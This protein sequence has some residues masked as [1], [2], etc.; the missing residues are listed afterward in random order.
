MNINE[1]RDAI[2]EQWIMITKLGG[3]WNDGYLA[4]LKYAMSMIDDNARDNTNTNDI[5]ASKCGNGDC[6]CK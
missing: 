6:F 5:Y 2:F 1:I 3:E 4:G